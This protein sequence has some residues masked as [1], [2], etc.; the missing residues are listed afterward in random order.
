MAP[1]SVRFIYSE[2]FIEHI[3][4]AACRALLVNARQA[5]AAD[6]VL[7]ISTPDIAFWVRT[8]LDGGL[9]QHKHAD[10]FPKTSCEMLNG[11]VRNWGH[12][13]IYDEVELTNLLHECG[14]SR[15]ERVQRNASRHPTLRNME[16]RP[17]GQDLILEAQL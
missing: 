11:I 8:Y 2:H 16:S 17:E 13:F 5:L 3:P 7:R 6:G 9:I 1:G 15:V 14:F 12:Q 4:P 10:W